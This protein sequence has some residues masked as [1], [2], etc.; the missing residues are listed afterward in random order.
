MSTGRFVASATKPADLPDLGGVEVA[1]AGRSNVGKSSL[2]G[3]VLGQAKLVRV[4]RT[5][6]RTQALNLFVRGDGLALVDLPGYG[7]AKL[8][9]AK[10][11]SLESM[12]RSYLRDR[13]ALRGVVLLVDARRYE[14]S[15]LDRAFAE[16]V[17]LGSPQLLVVITKADL[18]PKTRRR[19]VASVIEDGL[20]IP[21]GSALLCSAHS[22]DGVAELGACLSQL[23]NEGERP[24]GG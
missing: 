1:F 9:K 15:A 17:T 19:Q 22:G 18:V 20:G 6:G 10:R 12:L 3:A 16:W 2:L 23:R 7:Y 4:S 24:Q 13:Q 5:P 21:R 11:S 8:S 14:V